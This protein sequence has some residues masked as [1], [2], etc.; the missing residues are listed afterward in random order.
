[1]SRAQR[2]GEGGQHSGGGMGRGGVGLGRRRECLDSKL[3]RVRYIHCVISC[4]ISI[5]DCMKSTFSDREYVLTK[6]IIYCY[7][8]KSK[9]LESN[10]LIH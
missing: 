10:C 7:Y 6:T 9:R 8:R 4:C 3:I 1:M 5:G 2:K